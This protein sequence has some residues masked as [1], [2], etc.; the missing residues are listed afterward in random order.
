MRNFR[1]NQNRRKTNNPLLLPG[2]RC[3]GTCIFTTLAYLTTVNVWM[4][5][6]GSPKEWRLNRPAQRERQR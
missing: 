1:L 4:V 6:M 2:Y 5:V 3:N